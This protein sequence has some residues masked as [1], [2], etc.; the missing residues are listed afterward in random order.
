MDRKVQTRLTEETRLATCS[1]VP[2]CPRPT[3]LQGGRAFPP[4][5]RGRCGQGRRS[6]GGGRGRGLSRSSGRLRDLKP[7]RRAPAAGSVRRPG[8]AMQPL[9]AGLVPA[10]AREPRLTL[11]LRTG[12]GILAH[13]VALGFTIFLTVL[14]RPGTSECARRG[15]ARERGGARMLRERSW[16]CSETRSEDPRSGGASC[17]GVVRAWWGR[18]R[19]VG[20][21]RVGLWARGS[22]GRHTQLN[23]PVQQKRSPSWRMQVKE[24]KV[25]PRTGLT[26]AS[27]PAE[28]PSCRTAGWGIQA[29]LVYV[30]PLGCSP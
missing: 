12:S 25:H 3:A 16:E 20:P 9:E 11:W 4:A 29:R 2:F 28:L 27:C 5:S 10:P 18:P 22:E 24:A 7:G 14:S 26:A 15:G 1:L 19:E 13:L 23:S 8:P 30:F 6:V 17:G 21:G